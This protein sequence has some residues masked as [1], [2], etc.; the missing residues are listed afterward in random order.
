MITCL[1][2]F[3][4]DGC[5]KVEDAAGAALFLLSKRNPAGK[6]SMEKSL[7]MAGDDVVF[8]VSCRQT[9]LTTNHP[10]DVKLNM[11]DI[12][13]KKDGDTTKAPP[14]LCRR[15]T[16]PMLL[17]VPAPAFLSA[18]SSSS[19]SRRWACYRAHRMKIGAGSMGE[20][21]SSE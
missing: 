20:Q 13:S 6:L 16:I 15:P 21:L 5:C 19:T 8:A 10:I 2:L 14:R 18:C 11:I 3:S 17:E 7:L 4:P 9:N 1:V 12:P